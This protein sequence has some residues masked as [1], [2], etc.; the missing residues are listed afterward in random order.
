MYRV[1]GCVVTLLAVLAFTAPSS[2]VLA[3]SLIRQADFTPLS[4]ESIGAARAAQQ[5]SEEGQASTLQ[6]IPLSDENW[7]AEARELLSK[8]NPS[9]SKEEI[10]AVIEDVRKKKESAANT[11]PRSS[12]YTAQGTS[13]RIV[14]CAV[15]QGVNINGLSGGGG[16]ALIYWSSGGANYYNSWGNCP[17]DVCYWSHNVPGIP[18]IALTIHTAGGVN[19]ITHAF[20][21]CV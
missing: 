7:E 8:E 9:K 14:N 21:G 11:D 15:G 6:M 3:D 20:H 16:Y 1:L 19:W 10:D 5:T 13:E 18:G 12:D 4:N 2:R 17:A